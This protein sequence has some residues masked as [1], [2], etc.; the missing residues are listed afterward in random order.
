MRK[1]S[2][3]RHIDNNIIKNLT[4]F[5]YDKM[6]Q[7]LNSTCQK[8]SA[9]IVEKAVT[10]TEDE[11]EK[12]TDVRS[13]YLSLYVFF[14]KQR[15]LDLYKI[16]QRDINGYGPIKKFKVILFKEKLEGKAI[17]CRRR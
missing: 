10:E 3:K 2:I 12:I 11:I 13:K 8:F 16:E 7:E 17:W 9:N 14:A 6:R 4:S 15:I 5:G 1:D